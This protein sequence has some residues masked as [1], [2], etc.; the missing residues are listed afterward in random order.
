M[1]AL[2]LSTPSTGVGTMVPTTKLVLFYFHLVLAN[3]ERQW[4]LASNYVEKRRKTMDR[5]KKGVEARGS[6]DFKAKNWQERYQA[7]LH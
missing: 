4:K 2:Q 6:N 1:S 3:D 7:E 5:A